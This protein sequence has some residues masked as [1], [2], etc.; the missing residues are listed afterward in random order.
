MPQALDVYRNSTPF[1]LSRR[2]EMPGISLDADRFGSNLVLI[3][4]SPLCG[5]DLLKVPAEN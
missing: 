5:D 4:I 1:F 3:N 2:S